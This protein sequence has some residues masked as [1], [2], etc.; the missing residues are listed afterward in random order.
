MCPHELAAFVVSF[1]DGR[2]RAGDGAD[3]NPHQ[4]H[5]EYARKESQGRG[6]EIS[7]EDQQV[8]VHE[9]FH[10]PGQAAKRSGARPD[11]RLVF[12]SMRRLWGQR[13][14]NLYRR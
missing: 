10:L 9:H 1:A 11:A 6:H 4:K 8:L 13:R 3:D 5:E 7:S 12:R 14:N 2:S